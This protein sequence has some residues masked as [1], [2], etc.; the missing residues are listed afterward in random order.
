[1]HPA[2]IAPIVRT[3]EITCCDFGTVL[4][5]KTSKAAK[6]VIGIMITNAII[7]PMTTDKKFLTIS[8]SG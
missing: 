7:T 5:E 1:M 2:A 4:S 8:L 3:V 6:M